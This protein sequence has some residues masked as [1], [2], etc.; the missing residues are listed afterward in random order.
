MDMPGLERD[1]A[2]AFD[3]SSSS[4]SEDDHL[5]ADLS[6]ESQSTPPGSP[7]IDPDAFRDAPVR[8]EAPPTPPATP[9]LDVEGFESFT[10][11][12]KPRSAPSTE[13]ATPNGEEDG[14]IDLYALGAVDYYP[15]IHG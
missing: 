6:E 14:A 13:S 12:L 11:S 15:T 2:A 5:F 10:S 9:S 4:S 8:K 3:N 1:G 7:R